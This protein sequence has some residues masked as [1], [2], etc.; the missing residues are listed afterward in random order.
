MQRSCRKWQ[1]ADTHTQM[2]CTSPEDGSQD[3]GHYKIA[4]K[5]NICYFKKIK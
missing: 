3:I 1:T 5:L 2:S 4:I